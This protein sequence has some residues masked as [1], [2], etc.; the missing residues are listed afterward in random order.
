[1]ASIFQRIFLDQKNYEIPPHQEIIAETIIEGGNPKTAPIDNNL[2]YFQRFNLYYFIFFISVFLAIITIRIPEVEKSLTKRFKIGVND[3]V[4]DNPDSDKRWLFMIRYTIVFIS[5]VILYNIVLVIGVYVFTNIAS[6]FIPNNIKFSELFWSYKDVT[7]KQ[8]V[9]G[10]T[11]LMVLILVTL[12]TYVHYLG[13]TRWF[14]DWFGDMY[15]QST[16]KKKDDNQLQSYTY[17]YGLF[18]IAMM[19]FFMIMVNM[20]RMG[21]NKVYLTYNII[22]FIGFLILSFIII[23]EYKFGN[24]KK[25]AFIVIMVFMAFCL[26]PVLISLITTDIKSTDIFNSDFLMNLFFNFGLPQSS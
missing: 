2:E 25:L 22:F 17:N 26:Y 4:I 21:G 19:I 20:Q 11:Y 15:F 1:M 8:I 24:P 10:K 23:K 5:F 6:E 16:N 18:L 3:L 7:G 12:V 13:F 9:I 14:K